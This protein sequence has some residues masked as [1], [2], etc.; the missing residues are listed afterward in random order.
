MKKCNFII[1]VVVIMNFSFNSFC[2]KNLTFN[3][4]GVNFEMIFVEGGSLLL[5]GSTQQ[6]DKYYSEMPAHKVS[7]SNFY[8]GKYLITQELW[9]VVMGSSLRQQCLLAL[10]NSPG[11]MY[12][13][14][15]AQF[16]PEDY[17]KIMPLNGEGA[18]FPIYFINY[19]DCQRFCAR[20]NRLLADQLPADYEFTIPTE[21]Q[22]EYA[23][24]GG[25]KSKGYEYSGSNFIDEVAWYSMNSSEKTHEVGLKNR[26]EL[27]IYDM[28]G[29]V[30]EWC[31][32]L[33]HRDYN[34]GEIPTDPIPFN[35]K[36]HRVLR[37][38]SY[39]PNAWASLVTTRI[40][41][42]PDART[43]DRG[44]RI[45]LSKSPITLAKNSLNITK[46]RSLPNTSLTIKVNG[47]NFDMVFVEGGTYIIDCT[48]GKKNTDSIDNSFRN[49]SLSNFYLG[50]FEVTQELWFEVMGT[51][52]Q[53]QYDL[54][55]SDESLYG[56]GNDYPMYYVNYDEC[57]DFCIALNKLSANYLPEGYKFCLPNEVQWEY[58][59]RGGT[60][61]KK[62]TYSGSNTLSKVAW[63][64]KNSGNKVYEIGLKNKNELGIYDMS[65]NVWEWCIDWFDSN[66]NSNSSFNVSQGAYSNS[67]SVLRGGSWRSID[68][69]CRVTCRYINPFNERRSCIGFR[70]ALVGDN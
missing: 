67:H 55:L 16:R 42:D 38:G 53:Q 21:Y 49:V 59:A 10:K 58:A 30:W 69:G 4:N 34:I 43:Q 22:W 1:F 11:D 26:N 63:Y 20:L 23:A 6:G 8:M 51:T 14:R 29:N 45:V 24:R 15:V 64:G 66:C 47:V 41:G 37:G 18:N 36:Y 17:A 31:K 68:E 56:V 39:L 35:S 27:G 52:I 32:D 50:K 7:L 57:M 65:G 48:S 3:V 25:E 44:F 12:D 28:S 19:I 61:S 5:G 70:V 60:K 33:Y 2:Q 46:P 62:Y 54:A 40:N 9:N 13:V